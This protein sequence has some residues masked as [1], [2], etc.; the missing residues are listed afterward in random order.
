MK[1]KLVIAT[2]I[3]LLLGSVLY[4]QE[5]KV[6]SN[7]LFNLEA[8]KSNRITAGNRW[9]YNP[10]YLNV[11]TAHLLEDRFRDSTEVEHPTKSIEPILTEETLPNE[12]GE[13][14]LRISFDYSKNAEEVNVTLPQ[15]QLFFGIFENFGGEVSLPLEYRKKELG[16]YGIGSISTSVKW[17]ILNQ[18]NTNP[19]VVI[20]LEV[21]FPTNSF[22]ENSE[23][24]AFELSPYVAFIKEFGELIVQG[25]LARSTEF[26]VSGGEKNYRT[27][28]NIV[29]AYP[30]FNGKI[31]ILS[32]LNSSWL[33]HEK[34]KSSIAPGIKYNFNDEHFFALAV[35]VEVNNQN[36]NLRIIFQYQLQ[37]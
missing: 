35:P 2:T 18:G 31:D 5:Q 3:L 17:L 14:D 32:E 12:V 11:I 27:D 37:L 29:F 13:W 30:L 9:T 36:S 7:S 22:G 26:P 6:R 1:A 24:R 28:F 16:E 21:G 19:G 34:N 15:V 4:S 23:E 10:Y 8:P 33:T 25:N 20:G